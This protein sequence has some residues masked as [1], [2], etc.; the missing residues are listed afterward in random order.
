MTAKRLLEFLVCQIAG[1]HAPRDVK[2]AV[3]T[4]IGT[5]YGSSFQDK[6]PPL[7]NETPPPEPHRAEPKNETRTRPCATKEPPST[8]QTHARAPRSRRVTGRSRRDRRGTH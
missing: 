6:R 8:Q 1:R 4:E 7:D 2:I 3:L 5:V